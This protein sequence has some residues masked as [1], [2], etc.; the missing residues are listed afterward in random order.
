MEL[1][2]EKVEVPVWADKESPWPTDPRVN[3]KEAKIE[4]V[5]VFGD[6][7]DRSTRDIAK[8][9][10]APRVESHAVTNRFWRNADH[11]AFESERSDIEAPEVFGFDLEK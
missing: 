3:K 7:I 6:V 2:A 11:F 4:K 5:F 9:N 1:I 10:T 8:V